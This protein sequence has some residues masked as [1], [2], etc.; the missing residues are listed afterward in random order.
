MGKLEKVNI[1]ERS[2]GLE[3]PFLALTVARVGDV[4]LS[5]YLCAGQIQPHRHEDFDETFWVYDGVVTLATEMGSEIL[6]AGDVIVVPKGVN[7]WSMSETRSIVLLLR[8]GVVP[9]RKNG[10]HRLFAVLEDTA[11]A[12][13]SIGQ[14]AN[15]LR[16]MHEF[17]TVAQFDESAL[18]VGLGEGSWV[19]DVPAP[20]DVLL[21]VWAGTASVQTHDSV[22]HLHAGELSVVREGEVYHLSTSKNAILVRVTHTD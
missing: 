22:Q 11:Q 1:R 2:A 10:R 19:L 4:I 12:H 6:R 3:K 15:D 5:M 8:C 21:Y 17:K 9:H 13:V 18:Q 16:E 14:T 20:Q 7:H